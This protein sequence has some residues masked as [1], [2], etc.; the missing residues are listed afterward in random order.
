MNLL[1]RG[2]GGAKKRFE[3]I[4]M[5]VPVTPEQK[6]RDISEIFFCKNLNKAL[7]GSMRSPERKNINLILGC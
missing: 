2:T 5:R 4:V 6:Q 3:N 1:F 7:Y